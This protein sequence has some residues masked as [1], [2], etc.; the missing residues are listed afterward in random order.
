MK[1]Y[2]SHLIATFETHMCADIQYML[3]YT[4]I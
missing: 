2:M 1:K 3:L 4:E